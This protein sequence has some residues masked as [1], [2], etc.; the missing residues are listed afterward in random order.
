MASR[1]QL[2]S[3]LETIAVHVYFQPPSNVKM[4]Y[5]CLVYS[6]AA[7]DSKW[8]NNRRYR[9]TKRYEVTVIDRNPDGPLWDQVNDLALCEFDRHFNADNLNHDTFTLFF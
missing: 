6:R 7:Q 4:E 3:L 1:L 8:A 2:Q 9:A 5:P